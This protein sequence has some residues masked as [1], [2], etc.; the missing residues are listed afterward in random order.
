M[1]FKRAKYN[2]KCA[3]DDEVDWGCF[4]G[5]CFEIFVWPQFSLLMV[6]GAGAIVSET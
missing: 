3:H 5:D 4:A 6:N 1:E 2:G